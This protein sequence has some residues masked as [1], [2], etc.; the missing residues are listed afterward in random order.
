MSRRLDG[1]LLLLMAA[2]VIGCAHRQPRAITVATSARPLEAMLPASLVH[3]LPL[4]GYYDRQV[5]THDEVEQ[6]I[7]SS[8]PVPAAYRALSPEQCQSLSVKAS[9][10]GNRLATE[11]RV[12]I[13][14][15]SPHG[16]DEQERLKLQVLWAGE[17]EARN[18]SAAAALTLYYRIARAEA[19]RPILRKSLAEIDDALAKVDRLRTN[20][21]SVPFDDGELRRQRLELLDR[22]LSLTSQLDQLNAELVQLIGASTSEARP[23]LW[24]ATDFTVDVAPIVLDQAVALGLATRPE[25]RLLASLQSSL[26]AR[27]VGVTRGVVGGPTAIAMM[28]IAHF[29]KLIKQCRTNRRELPTRDRQL[30]ERYDER[31][32]E[33]TAEIQQAALE[34]MA[35]LERIALEKEIVASW[36]SQREKLSRQKQID[37]ATFIDLTHARL[38]LLEAESAE[39]E[40][41]IDW[42]LAHVKL[43]ESQGLLVAQCLGKSCRFLDSPLAAPQI[44]A[45]AEFVV[46]EEVL[47]NADGY[48]QPPDENA[49]TSAESDAGQPSG[50][51]PVLL[52]PDDKQAATTRAASSPLPLES[53]LPDMSVEPEEPDEPLPGR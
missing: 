4:S 40:Q 2:V 36:Q 45:P 32:R 34:V 38:K 8:S 3:P 29:C 19:N 27:N 20:G 25:L 48:Q 16:L 43:T 11:R 50:L 15:A 7:R 22:Q 49:P 14:T 37:E 17:L 39:I 46:P 33:L 18:H 51:P 53:P 13:A 44:N 52:L 23:R 6:Q 1:N 21:L 31:R 47:P 24:P 9:S 26:S 28:S 35:R 5:G 12:L 42:K 10:E 41:I 30:A